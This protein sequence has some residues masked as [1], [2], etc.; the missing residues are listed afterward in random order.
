MEAERESVRVA[1]ARVQQQEEQIASLHAE[2]ENTQR[3]LVA[4]QGTHA[5]STELCDRFKQRLAEEKVRNG[6]LLQS[7]RAS[8]IAA[9]AEQKHRTTAETKL[10]VTEEELAQLTKAFTELHQR[11]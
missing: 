3:D 6:K 10:R 5:R 8:T 9:N 1:T 4:L 2:H 11:A 7:L